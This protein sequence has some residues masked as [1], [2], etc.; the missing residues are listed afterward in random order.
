[1]KA[2]HNVV[3]AHD[4]LEAVS[5]AAAEKFDVIL[6]DINRPVLDGLSAARRIRQSN[7]PNRDTPII[8][9]TASAHS[10]GEGE[11]RDAGINLVLFKPLVKAALDKALVEVGVGGMPKHT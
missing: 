8:A 2:G 11:F 6:T 4:G 7:G 5:A 3:E 10:K 1:M 9:L